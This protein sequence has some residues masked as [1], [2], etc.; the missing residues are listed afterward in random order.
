MGAAAEEAR[1]PPDG[2]VAAIAGDALEG[3][4][5]VLDAGVGIGDDDG[6]GRLLDRG[7]Q[8]RERG[9][10]G[11]PLGDVDAEHDEPGRFAVE[12]PHERGPDVE[13]DGTAVGS[14]R[15]DLPRARRTHRARGELVEPRSGQIPEDGLEGSAQHL[16]GRMAQGGVGAIAPERDATCQVGDD[17]GLPHAGEDVGVGVELALGRAGLG[18]VHDRRDDPVTLGVGDAGGDGGDVDRRSALAEDAEADG[19]LA[20]SFAERSEHGGHGVAVLGVDVRSHARVVQSP[21]DPRRVQ[22]QDRAEA[23]G[24]GQAVGGH[25]D[26]DAAEAG[27]ALGPEEQLIPPLQGRRGGDLLAH[28]AEARDEARD[29]GVSGP[30][31]DGDLDP[32]DRPGSVDDAQALEARQSGGAEGPPESARRGT[33]TVGRVDERRRGPSQ[34]RAG[35]GCPGDAQDRLGRRARVAHAGR[36]VED[37]ERVRRSGR[38]EGPTPFAAPRGEDVSRDQGGDMRGPAGQVIAWVASRRGQGVR[39]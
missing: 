10:R 36:P 16:V 31:L 2:L 11:P 14:M 38:Q 17:D 39:H 29:P 28:V 8:A 33:A 27:K 1:V 35:P 24:Q 5:D 4:V 32:A 23:R 9:L 18:D 34:A 37:D 3:R 12:T 22:S 20:T 7:S 26:L 21:G 15:G 6:L 30:V 13:H 19:T 25:V